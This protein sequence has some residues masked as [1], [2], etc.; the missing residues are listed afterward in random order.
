MNWLILAIAPG[1]AISSYIILKDEYNREPRKHLLIS[2]FLGVLSIIP[3]MLLET[4]LFWTSSYSFFNSTL[5]NAVKAFL[6]VALPEEIAKFIMLKTYAYRQPEFDEPFDGIVYAV[7]VGMGF[8][9]AENIIYVYEYGLA[10]GVVRMFLA[11]PAH[12]TFAIIMGYFMGKAK[13]SQKRETYLLL[14]FHGSYDFF[15][16]LK[17]T[18]QIQSELSLWMLLGAIV[19][20]ITGIIL[21]KKAITAHLHQ[22]AEAH[23]RATND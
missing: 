4:P 12:A 5:G 1:V 6:L 14:V 22:S 21:S 20:L 11:V 7:M 19:S 13:F 18:Q 3:A 10:T 15:L 9:T 16:F 17:D 23:T 2:F 8:A